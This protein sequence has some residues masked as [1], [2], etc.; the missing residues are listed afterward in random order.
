VAARHGVPAEPLV[1]QRLGTN[2]VFA[3]G[4]AHVL[5]LFPPLWP[6][7]CA[8][9]RAALAHVAGRLSV[10]TP[11]V[12]AEG[13]L[14]GWPYLVLTRVPGV[15]L[16]DVWEGLGAAARERVARRAGELVAEHHALPLPAPGVPAP[17]WPGFVRAQALR[18]RERLRASR[19]AA[20][21]AEELD[22]FLAPLLAGLAAEPAVFVNADI[23]EEHLYVA[24]DGSGRVVALVDLADAMVG[25]RE[26]DLVSF[27][28]FLAG[29]GRGLLG[30]FL[31]GAGVPPAARGPELGRRLI[32]W[33][34]LH[35]YVDP[36]ELAEAAGRDVPL[37]ELGPLLFGA[38]GR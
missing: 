7:E 21:W 31:D 17:D 36:G 27:A 13:E 16:A 28:V 12:V 20:A 26:Y 5:K 35:R 11:E 29:R 19:R 9:E 1:R 23:T 10:A 4:A 3:A 2:V 38:S 33:A 37:A 8:I 30:R 34:L 15:A 24:E 18:A 25:A 22:G 14:E 32:A 6:G